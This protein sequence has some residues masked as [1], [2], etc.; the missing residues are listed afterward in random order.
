MGG[1]IH[2]P[3]QN[4]CRFKFTPSRGFLSPSFCTLRVNRIQFITIKIPSIS[5]RWGPS[6]PL[7]FWNQ[8][9]VSLCG[10]F[11]FFFSLDD[12]SPFWEQRAVCCQ[13]HTTPE[14]RLFIREAYGSPPH[15]KS[16]TKSYKNSEKT[17]KKWSLRYRC[18]FTDVLNNI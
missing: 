3:N 4:G 11:I 9:Q 13:L 14:P 7:S 6:A 12:S 16:Q 2:A 18:T 8:W 15:P 17:W 1:K 5:L 10:A